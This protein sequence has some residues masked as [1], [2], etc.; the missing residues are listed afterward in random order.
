MS[1]ISCIQPKLLLSIFSVCFAFASS[2]Q[3][4]KIT[5]TDG[6]FQLL[7]NN[8]PFFIK[9]AVAN[10]YFDRISIHGGNSIRSS[11]LNLDKLKSLDLKVLVDLPA[12]AE[13]NGF[14]YNDTV[15]VKKQKDQ[16][17]SI[18]R[19]IKDNPSILM[20]AIGNELDFIPQTLQCNLK[21]W[22]AINDI[23]KAIKVID[24]DHPIMTVVGT[25]M[26]EEKMKERI[27][28]CPELDLIGFN[29]YGDMSGLPKI[30]S[31]HGWNK[32]YVITEWGTD[33]YWE[34][35]RTKW[36]APYEQ[37]GLEK[38]LCYEKKYRD[39]ILGEQ[40]HCL[41]EFVFYWSGFKQE[42]THTWFC[43]FDRNGNESASVDV[44]HR[45]WLGTEPEN[46]AP[47][48][49]SMW[50]YGYQNTRSIYL[51]PLKDFKARAFASDADQDLLSFVWEIRPEATYASYA[52][53]GEKE[54]QPVPGLIK[55]NG[56]D[57]FFSTPSQEGAYRL[58]VYIYDGKGKFS[59]ANLP[60]YVKK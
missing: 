2:A 47:L 15:K 52:G 13:R 17:L 7:V 11:Y 27:N 14:D 3:S 25:D 9:G 50:I 56:A 36:K 30:L 1:K 49:D 16:I 26:I 45:L 23:A 58:F 44:M 24:P 29:T 20:W 22:D 5:D 39:V 10:E 40:G 53:Q 37:T 59:T 6:Y 33:G 60:L 31:K 57:I 19:D 12:G 48:I 41:G 4:V 43:M 8:K 46:H 38:A 42:T 28:R 35:P 51:S 21:L 55:T 34:T 54:P 32:P 18:V